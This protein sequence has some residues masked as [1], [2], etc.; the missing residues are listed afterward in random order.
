MSSCKNEDVTSVSGGNT[1]DLIL[2]E[3]DE[4]G[5]HG[6]SFSSRGDGANG[7][8]YSQRSMCQALVHRNHDWTARVCEF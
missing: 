7:S 6:P 1:G 5:P 4:M 8:H 2:Q 3:R